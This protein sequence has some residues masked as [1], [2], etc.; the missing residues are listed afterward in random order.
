MFSF[1][2]T[3]R[4]KFIIN[5]KEFIF[6]IN[7]ALIYKVLIYK[8]LKKCLVNFFFIYKDFFYYVKSVTFILIN[9]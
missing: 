2:L 5:W 7:K 3:S 6:Y 1:T 9:Y 4:Y 8:N